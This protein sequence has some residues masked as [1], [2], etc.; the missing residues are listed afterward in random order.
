[1]TKYNKNPKSLTNHPTMVGLPCADARC[2]LAKTYLD[3]QR[4]HF[5][6]YQELGLLLKATKASYDEMSDCFA[7]T[8]TSGKLRL[9]THASRLP[10]GVKL[11]A[12]YVRYSDHSSNTRSLDQQLIKVLATAKSQNVFIPWTYVFADAAITAT[13]DQRPGYQ[14]LRGLVKSPEK[15]PNVLIVDQLDRLHR[16]QE[17]AIRFSK[18]VRSRERQLMTSDGYD[19]T[20]DSAK[21]IQSL[22]SFQSEWYIDQL[23]AKVDRGMT[24]AHKHGKN[25]SS[26]PTGYK[27]VPRLDANGNPQ[28][29]QKGTLIRDVAVDDEAADVVRRIFEMYAYEK[30]SPAKIARILDKEQALGRSTW[31][32][33]SVSQLLKNDKYIGLWAWKKRRTVTDPETN[34]KRVVDNSPEDWLVNEFPDRQIVPAELWEAACRRHEKVSRNTRPNKGQEQSRQS[35][36]PNMLFDLHCEQCGRPLQ[37]YRS[38]KGKYIQLNC[39]NGKDGLRGCNLRSSKSLRII[40]E[41][42]LTHVKQHVF[43]DGFA[44]QLCVR[45]NEHLRVE[46]DKPPVDSKKLAR[47]IASLTSKLKRNADRLAD[48]DD[49]IAAD[50]L[51]ANIRDW[52]RE[53]ADLKSEQD[54]VVKANFRPEPLDIETV[55]TILDELRD[56]LREDVVAAHDVLA[57]MLGPVNVSLGE[58]QGR[59]Y[60]WR[61]HIHLNPVAGMVEIGRSKDCPT[62]H[63]MEYLRV[64]N[65]TLGEEMPLTI[66]DFPNYQRI[67]EEVVK[68][69]RAGS[70]MNSIAVALEFDP[71]TVKKAIEWGA[72]NDIRFIPSADFSIRRK[73]ANSK[74]AKIGAEVVRLRDEEGISFSQI[75]KKLNTTG[76]TVSRAYKQLHSEKNRAAV[77]KGMQLDT[78]G[79]QRKISQE[80]IKQIRHH[81]S[82]GKLSKRAIARQVGVSAWTVRHEARRPDVAT[83]NFSAK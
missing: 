71:S 65:W 46:A 29:T 14:L 19:S 68:M 7:E 15:H 55:K 57:G 66:V 62:S 54:R 5:P 12:A 39:P 28:T 83:S 44:E 34:R 17:E 77:I 45:A 60:T 23:K 33:S 63:S 43:G 73:H 3:E 79:T 24:D 40:E 37:R 69:H 81:L 32:T 82:E 25:V 51:M 22:T 78:G 59:T 56:L 48:L 6:E 27:L 38:M 8:Y 20:N 49:G 50:C 4:Q 80:Q 70:P 36:Y 58:K 21:L 41:C 10:T 9:F 13:T 64:C 26:I 1:M 67:A 61:A 75:A 76:G 72:K 16:N 31:G 74:T 30:M 42:I 53:L 18:L 11:G 47:D 35:Q 52:E 2:E